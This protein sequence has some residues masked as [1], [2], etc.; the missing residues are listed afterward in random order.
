M[1]QPCL[2]NIKRRGYGQAIAKIK[3]AD[4]FTA[5]TLELFMVFLNC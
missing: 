4:H 3:T 2:K 5:E 1:M